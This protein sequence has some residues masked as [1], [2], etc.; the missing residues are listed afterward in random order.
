MIKEFPCATTIQ[1]S[2]A[3]GRPGVSDLWILSTWTCWRWHKIH[4]KNF[5]WFSLWKTPE[6][7]LSFSLYRTDNI[8]RLT[9]CFLKFARDARHSK[10]SVLLLTRQK[11]TSSVPKDRICYYI[12]N[13][14]VNG[15]SNYKIYIYGFKTIRE[16]KVRL[17]IGRVLFLRTSAC[18]IQSANIQPSWSNKLRSIKDL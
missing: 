4:R 11:W 18:S 1:V 6:W 13:T 3:C 2:A 8:K 16:V 12:K 10:L 14:L 5:K 7:I 17:V 9:N 15:S